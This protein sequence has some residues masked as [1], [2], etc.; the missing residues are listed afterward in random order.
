M[1][2]NNNRLLLYFVF[3]NLT[4]SKLSVFNSIDNDGK[5]SSKHAL[6][7]VVYMKHLHI[8]LFNDINNFMLNIVIYVSSF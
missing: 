5:M 7:F 3:P 4:V 2:F 8:I 1:L 6:L